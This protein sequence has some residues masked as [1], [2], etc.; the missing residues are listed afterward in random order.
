MRTH[1][2]IRLSFLNFPSDLLSARNVRCSVQID[3][4][5]RILCRACKK[6]ALDFL[7]RFTLQ[8]T[9]T[10]AC[11]PFLNRFY[12]KAFSLLLL[13]LLLCQVCYVRFLKSFSLLCPF[14]SLVFWSDKLVTPFP[15]FLIFFKFLPKKQLFLR[16]KRHTKTPLWDSFIRILHSLFCSAFRRPL[17]AVNLRLNAYIYTHTHIR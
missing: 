2:W 12:T 16:E 10:R 15:Y 5:T 11:A 9:H 13:L 8:K 17:L 6:C 7:L 3:D 1:R 14:V 4:I